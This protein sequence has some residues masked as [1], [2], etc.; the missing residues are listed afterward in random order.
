M[1]RVG[2]LAC[3]ATLPGSGERRGDAYEHDLMMAALRPAFTARGMELVDIDWRAP[4]AEFDG[5]AL[6]LLG[7][8]WDYQD[9]AKEF[10]AR[11]EELEARGLTVCNPPEVVRWNFDKHYLAALAERG[12]PTVPTLWR[13]DVT[14]AEVVEAMEHFATDRVVVKRRVGAGGLGQHSFTRDALP[15]TGWRMGRAAMIQP[16]LPAIVE[17]GEFTLFFVEGQ[18]SHGVRKRPGPGEYRI[19]SLYGGYESDYAPSPADLAQAQAVVAALP[20]APPLYCRIDMCRL[21]SGE[22]AVMEAE[23]IEP[24]YYP[25]QGPEVG[26]LVADAVAERLGLTVGAG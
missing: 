10:L 19:Q 1:V 16:F 25:E 26:R 11:L 7:T 17:E 18:F 13:D 4:L 14:C 23:M 12:A 3:A 9:H 20:F 22:L 15:E 21:A 24:Y 6:V 2:F 5:V 8:A